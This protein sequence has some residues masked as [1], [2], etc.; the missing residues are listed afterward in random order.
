MLRA[1][2]EQHGG[3]KK[4]DEKSESMRNLG[5]HVL[6]LNLIAAS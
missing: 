6:Q 5:Y 4:G 1:G 2:I 3:T